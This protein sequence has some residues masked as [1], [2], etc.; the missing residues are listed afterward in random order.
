MGKEGGGGGGG[1]ISLFYFIFSGERWDSQYPCGLDS[2][3]GVTFVLV[4]DLAGGL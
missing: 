3:R 1:V 2:S 4:A